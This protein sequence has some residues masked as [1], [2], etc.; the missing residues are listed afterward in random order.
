MNVL[1]IAQTGM[2][3]AVNRFERSAQQT[4]NSFTPEGSDDDLVQGVVGQI[5]A[6]HEF[7]AS[8]RVAQ[9]ADEMMGA[10]LDIKA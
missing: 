1:S 4:L 3:S 7:K 5:Q 8:V 9:V 10:L 2:A 6:K